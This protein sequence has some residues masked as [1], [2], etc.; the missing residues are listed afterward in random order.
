MLTYEV[1]LRGGLGTCKMVVREGRFI[2]RYGLHGCLGGRKIT[3]ALLGS[4]DSR[5]RFKEWAVE[6][7]GG[8]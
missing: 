5:K 1:S 2:R 4:K 3:G 8:Q 7:T 6:G